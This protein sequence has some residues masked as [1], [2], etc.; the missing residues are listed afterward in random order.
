M[1]QP[2]KSE[3][4]RW[5]LH[6]KGASPRIDGCPWLYVVTSAL[7][8]Q[9]YV[10][11]MKGIAAVDLIQAHG[12][13]EDA[14]GDHSHDNSDGSFWLLKNALFGSGISVDVPFTLSETTR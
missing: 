8:K 5:T 1:P 10:V 14:W 12:E 9:A 2:V 11:P 3:T 7:R 13:V 4:D 6:V